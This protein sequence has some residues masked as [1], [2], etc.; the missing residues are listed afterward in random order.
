MKHGAFLSILPEAYPDILLGAGTVLTVEQAKRAVD[1]G[2]TYIVSP[3][4]GRQVVEYC[5]KK[6]IAVTP[7]AVTPTE[8]T[9][10]RLS[11]QIRITA[12]SVSDISRS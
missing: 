9:A 10:V 11:V 2:A 8:V 5:V 6:D 1:A 4:F 3:G 7:G 12:L